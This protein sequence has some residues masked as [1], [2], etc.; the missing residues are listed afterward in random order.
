MNVTLFP[1]IKDPWNG[2]SLPLLEILDGIKSGKWESEVGLY[3]DIVE[4]FGK[5]SPEAKGQ[6]AMIPNFTGSGTFKERYDKDLIQHSGFIVI[7]FDDLDYNRI[8]EVGKALKRDKYSFAVFDSVSGLGIATIVKIDPDKHLESFYSLQRY[9]HVKYGLDIDKSCKNVSRARFVS[10]DTNLYVNENSTSFDAFVAKEKSKMKSF[11]RAVMDAGVNGNDIEAI[12]FTRG[13]LRKKSN[14]DFSQGSRN[15]YSFILSCFC[16][17]LSI[18]K[19]SFKEYAFNTF[20]LDND[21]T[22]EEL[23]KTIDNAYSAS[24]ADPKISRHIDDGGGDLESLSEKFPFLQSFEKETKSESKTVWYIDRVKYIDWLSDMGFGI[25]FRARDLMIIRITENIIEEYTREK[26]KSFIGEY[27]EKWP[28]VRAMVMNSK[29]GLMTVEAMPFLK[30]RGDEIETVRDSKD[31]GWLFFKNGYFKVDRNGLSKIHHYKDMPFLIWKSTIQPHTFQYT[32]YKEFNFYKFLKNITKQDPKRLD[33]LL[34]MFG[35]Y[36]HTYKDPVNAKAAVLVDEDSD[37]D[38]AN[39]GTGKSILTKA[40]GKVRES[41]LEDGKRFG[42]NNIR[43]LYQK[44]KESTKVLTIDDVSRFFDWSLL[45]SS[46][47][48]GMEVEGKGLDPF[49]LPFEDAPKIVLT[50]NYMVKAQD[51][52]TKRRFIEVEIYN[53]YSSE[54][55]PFD[56]FGERFFDDWQEDDW[57]KF[58][59]IMVDSLCLYLNKGFMEVHTATSGIAKLRTITCNEFVDFAWKRYEVDGKEYEFRTEMDAFLEMYPDFKE[60]KSKMSER[61]FANWLRAIS[62]VKEFKYE[63]ERRGHDNT[64]Y[65]WFAPF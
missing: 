16:N 2:E 1:N 59:S 31:Y 47:T 6:K 37:P 5:D 51:E 40:I 8:E 4:E 53:H 27:L 18:T 64:R 52:S 17:R 65:F 34:T 58:Y 3:R 44:V 48:S 10:Y 26:L 54:N 29:K 9:Y 20:E 49:V 35:Y 55:T 30:N 15:N 21:F 12:E 57:N 22:P 61:R 23:Q 36:I 45:F 38:Q 14:L 39:G 32:D 41:V 24:E 46:I 42:K 56:D 11:S 60:G 43:F 50:T 13:Y 28:V 19:E 62:R 63:S 25:Y 33:A 7:D